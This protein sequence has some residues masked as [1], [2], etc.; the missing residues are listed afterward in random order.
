MSVKENEERTNA[1]MPGEHLNPDDFNA[2]EVIE[3]FS[4]NNNK[5]NGV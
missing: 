2:A 1:D 4:D 3:N 5:D